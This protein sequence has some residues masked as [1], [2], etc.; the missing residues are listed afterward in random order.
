MIAVKHVKKVRAISAIFSL[1]ESNVLTQ[2]EFGT[3]KD[4]ILRLVPESNERGNDNG[5]GKGINGA[6]AQRA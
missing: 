1:V 2:A 6:K 5:N 4:A 3:L